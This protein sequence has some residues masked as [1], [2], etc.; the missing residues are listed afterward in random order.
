MMS[1][2]TCSLCRTDGCG[3]IKQNGLDVKGYWGSPD[4]ALDPAVAKFFLEI[5]QLVQGA[6]SAASLVG[7]R[8]H[9]DRRGLEGRVCCGPQPDTAD[10]KIFLEAIQL[11]EIGKLE[12]SDI[13]AR[14]TD[15]LLQVGNDLDQIAVGEAGAQELIPKPLPVKA[16]REVLTGKTAIGLMQLLDLRVHRWS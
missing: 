3:S 13:T 16:Q 8:D 4:G 15:F 2:A 9:R 6:L 10:V 1:K 12:R 5:M 7:R 11:E 14:L